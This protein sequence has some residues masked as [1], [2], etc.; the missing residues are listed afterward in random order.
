MPAMPG[1]R[2]IATGLSVR[3]SNGVSGSI[4]RPLD[5][6][7]V[8]VAVV[9]D[10]LATHAGAERALTEI[11][12]IWPQAELFTL[13]DFLP[14]AD[15]AFLA[16]RRITTSFLQHWPFAR[17]HFRKYVAWMRRA[18]ESFDLSGFDLVVSS[19]H[20]FAKGVRTRP[21]QYHLCYCY[22]PMRYAW[23]MEGEYLDAFGMSRGPL[24][25][26]A[27]REL[28]SL[29]QWDRAAATRVTDMVAISSYVASRIRAAY[30]R[31]S[32]VI[33]PPVD[34][35][36]FQL[37]EAKEAFYLT[38]SR[39]VPYKNV[40]TIVNAFRALPDRQLVVIGE[41]AE[42][43]AIARHCPANVQL[44]GRVPESVVIDH[45]QRARAF[46]FAAVEDFGIAPVEALACGTPVIALAKGGALETVRG[47]VSDGRERTGVFFEDA[48][49]ESIV[50]AVR[51]FEVLDPAIDAQRCR[52]RAME[53]SAP[54]FRR[55]FLA[56]AEA[57]LAAYRGARAA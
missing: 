41:G 30:G 57:G 56:H 6:R 23:A 8:K 37:R 9:H 36:A 4:V 42:L 33:Y 48:T 7:F 14:P 45:M 46:L 32:P 52:A 35:E 15:R 31:E 1:L 40:A 34:V 53:F 13:V 50:E 11:L 12:A 3:P 24:G 54:R 10:W 18:M 47:S 39:L 20:A 17:R 38:V 44:L 26:L 55:E 49:P 25:W 5:D 29:R 51:R 28:A 16:G 22:T 43:R 2:P 21:G 19:A 27:R